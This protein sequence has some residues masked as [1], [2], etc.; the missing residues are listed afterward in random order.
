[1]VVE[2]HG[3]IVDLRFERKRK[4]RQRKDGGGGNYKCGVKVT[5]MNTVWHY[6]NH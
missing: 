6:D 3:G 5:T 2:G 4:K 1:M